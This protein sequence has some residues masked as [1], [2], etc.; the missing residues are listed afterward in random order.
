[1]LLPM[2]MVYRGTRKHHALI[3]EV[4]HVSKEILAQ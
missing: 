1:M 2:G 3:G 4:Q